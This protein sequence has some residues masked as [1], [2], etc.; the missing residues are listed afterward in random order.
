M[1]IAE[2]RRILYALNYFPY[3]PDSG[4]RRVSLT[5]L[6]ELCGYGSVDLVCF[7]DGV[8]T[9]QMEKLLATIDGLESITVVAHK[10]KSRWWLPVLNM[11]G[12]SYF[13]HRDRSIPYRETLK[14]LLTEKEHD[15]LFVD[16]ARVLSNVSR[17]IGRMHR[18]F[19]VIGQLFNVNTLL[20]RRYLNRKPWLWTLLWLEYLLARREEIRFWQSLDQALFISSRDCSIASTMADGRGRFD[21]AFPCPLELDV[22]VCEPASASP[23]ILHI[24]TGSWLPNVD[25]LTCFIETVLPRVLETVPEARFRAVGG[26]MPESL[27]QMGRRN[28]VQMAGFVRDLEPEYQKAALFVVPLQFGS[29]IKIKILD[30]MARGLPVVATPV[31]MEGVPFGMQH[32]VITAGLPE[33]FADAVV[34]LLQDPGRRAEMGRKAR[35]AIERL[36]G[37]SRLLPYLEQDRGMR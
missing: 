17:L 22:P 33:S 36:A 19:R 23:L 13:F 15:I 16:T 12:R 28:G 14:K 27:K 6:Y 4:G 37:Q 24:G 1:N 11:T 25:G 7:D 30:A 34:A 29:G 18:R 10:R 31:A 20:T 21:S 32:G 3:P 2:T 35:H 5:T 9:D 26:G 8:E